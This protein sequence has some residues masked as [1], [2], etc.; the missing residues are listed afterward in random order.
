[1]LKFGS[2][3]A[4]K[5]FLQSMGFPSGHPFSRVNQRGE[6]LTLGFTCPDVLFLLGFFGIVEG[7]DWWVLLVA[8]SM[9][10]GDADVENTCGSG[11]PEPVNKCVAC[12]AHKKHYTRSHFSVPGNPDNQYSPKRFLFT[13]CLTIVRMMRD[14]RQKKGVRTLGDALVLL[15]SLSTLGV[16]RITS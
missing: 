4:C 12:S 2:K 14:R 16:R 15:C 5:A 11:D 13:T 10:I 9:D 7:V 3:C 8:G 1:M 6:V